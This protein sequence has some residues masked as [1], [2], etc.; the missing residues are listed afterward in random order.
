MSPTSPTNPLRRY[1]VVVDQR[2]P[3][4]DTNWTM[5]TDK[6]TAD[7]L[8]I[9]YY[10]AASFST[11]TL[12]HPMNVR[13]GDGK[14]YGGYINYPLVKGKTYNYEV[15][16]KWNMNGGQPVIA[17]LRGECARVLGGSVRV[18]SRAPDARADAL[19]EAAP[20]G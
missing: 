6:V 2:E 16:T 7:R 3:A 14:V 9:P 17:R 12:T 20:R 15:Y 11:E 8:N 13:I 4:G 5:L 19:P 18:L 1:Y 10:V